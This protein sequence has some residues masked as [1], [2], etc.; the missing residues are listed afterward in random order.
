MNV[1]RVFVLGLLAILGL[2]FLLS[3]PVMLLWNFLMPK[4]FGLI[5]LTWFESWCLM[6]LAGFL[7]KSSSVSTD[8]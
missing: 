2:S 3:F 5:T 4:I 1:L 6:I 8:K 7:F